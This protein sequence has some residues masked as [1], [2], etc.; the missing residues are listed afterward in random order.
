M[1]QAARSPSLIVVENALLS[2][3]GSFEG[4]AMKIL[5]REI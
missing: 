4:S 5:Q 2:H 3:A 1:Q